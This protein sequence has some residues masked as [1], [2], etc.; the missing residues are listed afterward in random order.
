MIVI[1]VGEPYP[2]NRTPHDGAQYF[3]RQGF[4]SLA[5]FITNPRPRE[6]KA[7]QSGELRFALTP[8]QGPPSLLFLLYTFPAAFP[9]SDATYHIQLEPP[10]LRPTLDTL[11]DDTKRLILS[12]VLIDRATRIVK[13]LRVVSFSAQFSR[14]L[15][16]IV[17][18]QLDEPFDREAYD[19]ALARAY[20]QHPKPRDLLARRVAHCIEWSIGRS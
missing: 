14:A 18:Q 5:L 15:N 2:L 11:S 19:A 8:L 16:V 7:V 13:A 20:Q 4:H 10:E 3:Y 12:I 6:M 9:W 1:E 17:R